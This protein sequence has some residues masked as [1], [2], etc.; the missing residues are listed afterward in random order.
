MPNIALLATKDRQNNGIASQTT[1]TIPGIISELMA[2]TE[3]DLNSGP[4]SCRT[5]SPDD[6]GQ[7]VCACLTT[8]DSSC[9]Y[10]LGP[11]N[12]ARDSGDKTVQVKARSA[13]ER[14]MTRKSK[15][16]KGQGGTYK[17]ILDVSTDRA[18][19]RK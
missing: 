6:L 18:R 12:N 9:S 10:S 13:C 1:S 3:T 11:R 17:A 16:A 19:M 2:F 8:T 15:L 7:R 4:H 14:V 5:M